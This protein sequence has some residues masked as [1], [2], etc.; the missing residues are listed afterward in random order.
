MRYK[1]LFNHPLRG[2]VV[3]SLSLTKSYHLTHA[4]Q[5]HWRCLCV[6]DSKHLYSTYVYNFPNLEGEL[7]LYIVSLKGGVLS[8][9]G[10]FTYPVGVTMGNSEGDALELIVVSDTK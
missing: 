5:K 9:Y 8:Y 6:S 3:L 10:R 1:I 2:R 7:S 4:S